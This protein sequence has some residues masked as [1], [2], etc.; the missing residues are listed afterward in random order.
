MASD[1]SDKEQFQRRGN[2]KKT[3][4]DSLLQIWR[5][6]GEHVNALDRAVRQNF[7]FWI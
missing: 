6:G 7:G 5:M 2:L 4:T 3:F 1:V